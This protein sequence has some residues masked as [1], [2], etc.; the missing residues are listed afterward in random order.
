MMILEMRHPFHLVE[1]SPWPLFI[2]LNLLFFLIGFVSLLHGFLYGLSTYF[3]S[4]FMVLTI[5]ISW[6][7]DII[8]ESLYLGSHSYKTI[9]SL[10]L[11]FLL[12]LLTE[13]MLFF[14]LFWG[15]FHNALNPTSL[16]F[17]PVGI[18]LVNP[19]AIPLLNTTLLLFSGVAITYSH[20]S[21]LAFKRTE[22]VAWLGVGIFLGIIFTFLQGVEYFSSSFDITDS[23][24]GSAFFMLTGGHGLHV[25]VGM[26]FLSVAFIRL[27]NFTNPH[28]VFDLAVLY[29]HFVDL[30][31]I[32]LFIL[33]YY[34]CY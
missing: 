2:S 19:W 25:I 18:E 22:T 1:Q 4:F 34:M 23:S 17:P 7:Y 13:V 11:G 31:W 20:H 12:F 33:I 8:T 10:I 32:I 30:V 27:V 15:Y 24:Y 6:F 9:R 26:I 5:F 3:F 14:S 16:V 28:V 29:W 21:F